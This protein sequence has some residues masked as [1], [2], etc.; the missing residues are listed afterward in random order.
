MSVK[1]S[2]ELSFYVVLTMP[3]LNKACLFIYFRLLPECQ[4]QQ[5]VSYYGLLTRELFSYSV[6]WVGIVP[7]QVDEG[8]IPSQT[9]L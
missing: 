5:V 9:T 6:V 4:N 2:T 3:T 1:S 7:K 8:T